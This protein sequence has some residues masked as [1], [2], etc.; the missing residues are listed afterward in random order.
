MLPSRYSLRGL[1]LLVWQSLALLNPEDTKKI[2]LHVDCDQTHHSTP[3]GATLK[4]DG[5][6]TGGA[7][8]EKKGVPHASPVGLLLSGVRSSTGR[9]S[10]YR[11]FVTVVVLILVG[12][13]AFCILNSQSDVYDQYEDKSEQVGGWNKAYQTT[14]GRRKLALSFLLRTQIVTP[15]QM[16][17]KNVSDEYVNKALDIADGM[18][19]EKDMYRWTDQEAKTAFQSRLG[20]SP[21]AMMRLREDVMG[22]LEFE[23]SS[24]ATA[25]RSS[26]GH[27]RDGFV[28]LLKCGIVSREEFAEAP[29]SVKYIEERVQAAMRLLEQ[30]TL[31]E[32]VD[33][34]RR[35]GKESVIAC[36][37]SSNEASS[38]AADPLRG[39]IYDRRDPSPRNAP[40]STTSPASSRQ[41]VPPIATFPQSHS[42]PASSVAVVECAGGAEAD[43][44]RRNSL[45]PPYESAASVGSIPSSSNVTPNVSPPTPG[46]TPDYTPP[47]STEVPP[48]GRTI[49]T[50]YFPPYS[51]PTSAEVP[52]AQKSDSMTPSS[53]STSLQ[54]APK[55][56]GLMKIALGGPPLGTMPATVPNLQD[57]QASQRSSS[58]SLPQSQR[59][60]FDPRS[61]SPMTVPG[62]SGSQSE[63]WPVQIK[64]ANNAVSGSSWASGASMRARTPPATQPNL[65]QQY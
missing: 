53:Y 24:W 9:A 44:P 64:F 42:D 60:A 62:S 14:T 57:P 43:A 33:Q 52:P 54:D 10:N 12:S 50:P 48:A 55:A 25:Y 19:Q 17:Q 2:F 6:A 35:N 11:I 3:C 16:A 31:I 4:P 18:L 65:Y 56:G 58:R 27:R 23:D 30:K 46:R 8:F 40:T 37:T 41:A 20:G 49:G 51:P 26:P 5:Y 22:D 36:F 38:S 45:E 63:G 15:E 34:C 59:Q 29:A 47:T 1:I 39:T 61:R 28:L 32:W 21:E 7:S 13:I